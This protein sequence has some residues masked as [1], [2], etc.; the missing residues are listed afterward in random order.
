MPQYVNTATTTVQIGQNVPL[1]DAIPCTRGLALHRN[2]SG[3]VTLRGPQNNCCRARYKVSFTANIAVA[4][5]G[6]VG[7]IGVALAVDGEPMYSATAIV[8]PAAI[9]DFFNVDVETFVDVPRCCC[10]SVAVENILPPTGTAPGTA[11]DVANASL[12]ITREA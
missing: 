10:V 9:G 7:P 6:T 8:T 3:I 1:I 4:T 11:I 12:I 5:G 2:G